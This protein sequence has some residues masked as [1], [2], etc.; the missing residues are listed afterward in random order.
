[1]DPRVLGKG[2]MN[3]NH[4]KYER[5]ICLERRCELW[6]WERVTGSWVR[7]EKPE[8]GTHR[9]KRTLE[10]TLLSHQRVLGVWNALERE[11]FAYA[12]ERTSLAF[13]LG[14]WFSS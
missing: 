14:M 10:G 3:S 5:R 13:G 7:R 12:L 2:E 8:R 4:S 1:M 11:V 6:L 9:E